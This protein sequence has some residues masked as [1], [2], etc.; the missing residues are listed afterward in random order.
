[1]DIGPQTSECMSSNNSLALSLCPVNEDFV[2]L[3]A[4]HDSQVVNHS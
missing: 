4:R 1:M 3:P 2:I